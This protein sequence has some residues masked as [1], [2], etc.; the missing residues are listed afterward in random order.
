LS[1]DKYTSQIEISVLYCSLICVSSTVHD[2]AV[3][4]HLL[5]DSAEACSTLC[6]ALL[7][8]DGLAIGLLNLWRTFGILNMEYWLLGLNKGGKGFTLRILGTLLV[9]RELDVG[10]DRADD[11][12]SV[13]EAC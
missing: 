7:G 12:A 9:N 11:I 13:L 5:D 3:E 8:A 10:E 6:L 2:P 4:V 1:L